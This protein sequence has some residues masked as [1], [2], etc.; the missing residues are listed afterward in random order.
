MASTTPPPAT[1]QAPAPSAVGAFA[2]SVPFREFFRYWFRLG[3]VNFGG[4]AGQ[5]A[6][7]HKDVVDARG[8]IEEKLF[9]RALN[10]CMLLPGPEAHQLAVYLGWRLHGYLGGAVA[11]LCFLLPSVL[12]MLFL[13]WLAAAHGEVPMIAAVFRAIAGAV[14]AIV[15]QAVWRMAKKTLR[16]PVFYGFAAASFLMGYVLKLKFPGI[17]VGAG[18]MGLWLG[19]VR[20][21]LFCPGGVC[22]AE[23]T[24]LRPSEKPLRPSGSPL[25]RVD[26]PLRHLGRVLAVFAG[27]WLAVALPV[28]LLSAPGSVLPKILSFYTKASFV[29]FGGAYAVLSHVSDAVVRLGWVSAEQVVLGLGLAETTPGP[30]IM[31]TQYVGFLSAWNHPGALAPLAAG[32]LGGLVTTFGMFLPSFMIV[33]AG[34]PYIESLTAN[35]HIASALTGITAAVVGV[36]LKL[37]VVFAVSTFLPARVAANM[38]GVSA[39]PIAGG[40]G[41]M[42]GGV[43]TFAVA[44]ALAC[45]VALWR[46]NTGVHLLV[47]AAGAAGGLWSLLG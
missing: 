35:K 44:V 43:D 25:R 17:V 45:A 13:S 5:I 28:Y 3:F 46:W 1:A 36:V 47:L 12:L 40:I 4:P 9:L 22:E 14:V 16:H 37:G 39:G 6:M 30:L 38:A 23:P 15:A 27:L 21:D 7:M 41:G 20:P 2:P 24:P 10:F 8:W 32:I 19:S 18:I 33:F 31:V 42:V 11:G 26:K 34:A 29:T